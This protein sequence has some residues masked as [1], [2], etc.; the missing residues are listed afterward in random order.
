MFVT[1]GAILPFVLIFIAI[2]GFGE[3]VEIV[4]FWRNTQLPIFKG[5]ANLTNGEYCSKH[6]RTRTACIDKSSAPI[7]FSFTMSTLFPR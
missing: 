4:C 6:S 2:V 1:L 7:G 3:F 5:P